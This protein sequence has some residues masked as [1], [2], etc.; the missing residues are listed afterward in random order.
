VQN[1]RRTIAAQP[2]ALADYGAPA[3]RTFAD[4]PGLSLLSLCYLARRL[5]QSTRRTTLP[6]SSLLLPEHGIYAGAYIEAVTA[7]TTSPSRKSR[8]RGTGR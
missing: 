4:L 7:R 5:S 3:F 2:S 6:G 1:C 8:I